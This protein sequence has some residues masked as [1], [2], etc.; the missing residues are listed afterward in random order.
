MQEPRPPLIGA[1]TGGRREESAGLT[2]SDIV[3][4]EE[5]GGRVFHIR[6]TAGWRSKNEA[7]VRRVPVHPH[8]IELGLLDHIE[9]R[10]QRKDRDLFPDLRPSNPKNSYGDGIDDNVRKIRQAQLS[11]ESEGKAFHSFRHYVMDQLKCADRDTSGS[12]RAAAAGDV[13]N[14][15]SRQSFLTS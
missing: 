3:K 13:E 4:A 11:P 12:C 15:L 9:T 10:Q 14:A 1:Y 6:F 2:V 7:S 8:L 5:D